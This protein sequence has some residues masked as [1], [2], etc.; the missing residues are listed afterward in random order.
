M[1]S[2]INLFIQKLPCLVWKKQHYLLKFYPREKQNFD[3]NNI[4]FLDRFAQG[5]NCP[6][7]QK[8]INMQFNS[9]QMTIKLLKF[10]NVYVKVMNTNIMVNGFLLILYLHYISKY[11]EKKTTKTFQIFILNLCMLQL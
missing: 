10:K 6:D 3:K 8:L 5:Q 9:E 2:C 7:S 1:H 11:V 4:N